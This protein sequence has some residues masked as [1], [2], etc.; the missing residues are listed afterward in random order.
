MLF[1]MHSPLLIKL[2]LNS[3]VFMAL[4]EIQIMGEIRMALLAH[5]SPALIIK[6]T[7]T[8]TQLSGKPPPQS[9]PSTDNSYIYVHTVYVQYG[10]I[11]INDDRI[12][13]FILAMFC[14]LQCFDE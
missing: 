12:C 14:I 5:S 10:K 4:Y 2:N 7:H 8:H 1:R 6:H 11:V 3:C 13:W 9:C